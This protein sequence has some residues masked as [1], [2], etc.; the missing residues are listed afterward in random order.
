MKID[1]FPQ[2]NTPCGPAAAE[3]KR[4]KINWDGGSQ[5]GQG[6]RRQ[7]TKKA[8]IGK[9]GKWGDLEEDPYLTEAWD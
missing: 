6:L 7:V 9:I 1:H 3:A 5:G 4:V 8:D 2:S